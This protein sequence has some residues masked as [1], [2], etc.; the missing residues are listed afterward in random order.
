MKLVDRFVFTDADIAC[1]SLCNGAEGWAEVDGLRFRLALGPHGELQLREL[2]EDAVAQ[3]WQAR[4]KGRAEDDPAVQRD[5]LWTVASEGPIKGKAVAQRTAHSYVT[6][7]KVL[8][9]FKRGRLVTKEADGY[10]ITPK[11][12][13]RL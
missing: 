10:T 11:G 13:K 4:R 9:A 8:A 12:Q 1:V 3:A 6:V 7:R 2:A 5:I